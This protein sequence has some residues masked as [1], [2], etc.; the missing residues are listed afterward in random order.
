MPDEG[1]V[2]EQ[3]EGFGDERAECGYCEPQYV[4]VECSA[5]SRAT[6]GGF[7]GVM[8]RFGHPFT[9]ARWSEGALTSAAKVMRIGLVYDLFGY[10]YC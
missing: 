3:E 4:A 6:R 2:D 5:F 8:T 9:V 1:G 10:R 7:A